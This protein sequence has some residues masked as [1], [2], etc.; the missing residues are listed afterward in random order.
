MRARCDRALFQSTRHQ[1]P[2]IIT[3]RLSTLLITRGNPFAETGLGF[4]IRTTIRGLA[5]NGPVDVLAISPEETPGTAPHFADVRPLAGVSSVRFVSMPRRNVHLGEY[6]RWVV[7]ASS[8]R[9]LMHIDVCHLQRE[10]EKAI[11]SKHKLIWCLTPEAY[12]GLPEERS[13]PV[14]VDLNDF[15]AHR[16]IALARL[17]VAQASPWA[18]P[19]QCARYAATR[20]DRR[21]ERSKYSAIAAEVD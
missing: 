8:P 18:L 16:D 21:G 19:G 5:R 13:V 1:A 4:R 7:R 17:R 10:F 11:L 20:L 15:D 3:A 12:L 2:G 14:A 6:V 9:R